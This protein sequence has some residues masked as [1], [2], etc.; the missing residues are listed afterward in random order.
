V[1]D[2]AVYCADI[3][4]IRKDQFAWAKAILP[5]ST[6]KTRGGQS[7]RALV[8]SL[9]RDLS[10]DRAVALGFECPLFVP[11]TE[12]PEQLTA[13]RPGEGNRSWS[14]GG[15]AGSLTVGLTETVW[16]LRELLRQLKVPVSVYLDWS[17]FRRADQGLFL[18]EAFVSSRGKGK[19]HRADADAAVKRFASSLPDLSGANAIRA[20]V[21]H[22][23]IGAALLRTGWS[24]DLSLLERPCVV[25]RA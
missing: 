9:A 3:G 10:R 17:S 4:S 16:V 22:S 18:W 21:V 13:A 24:N 6:L 14:A 5:G 8:S 12:E 11:V 20:D 15:G 19:N 2:L 25:I 7:I 23:L 1:R